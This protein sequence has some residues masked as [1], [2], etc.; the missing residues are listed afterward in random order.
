MRI[1]DQTFQ[2]YDYVASDD[3]GVTLVNK[4]VVVQLLERWLPQ[5]GGREEHRYLKGESSCESDT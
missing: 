5:P 3:G 4:R 1:D 2:R